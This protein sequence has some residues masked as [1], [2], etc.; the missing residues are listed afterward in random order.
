MPYQWSLY[1]CKFRQSSDN[2]YL[3]SIRDVT[4]RCNVHCKGPPSC[5]TKKRYALCAYQLAELPTQAQPNVH[6]RPSSVRQILHLLL[7]GLALEA[8]S[9]CA[10]LGAQ[11]SKRKENT[12]NVTETSYL[13]AQA[14][15]APESLANSARLPQFRHPPLLSC[16]KVCMRP[17]CSPVLVSSIQPLLQPLPNLA[18]LVRRAALL[19]YNP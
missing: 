16:A 3:S 4:Q 14:S 18:S 5:R 12:Y 7:Q 8:Q 15:T 13:R 19:L 1:L 9:K 2:V 10:H 17:P 11:A 6:G